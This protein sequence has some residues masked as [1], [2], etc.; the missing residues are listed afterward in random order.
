MKEFLHRDLKPDNVLL[1]E[2]GIPK[3]ADFGLAKRIFA[4]DIKEDEVLVGTPNFMAPELFQGTPAT[5]QS[6]VYSLGV[7]YFYLLTGTLPFASGS[8]SDLRNRAI[9]EP[10]PN[11]RETNPKIPL[12]DGRMFESADGEIAEEPPTRWN[13]SGSITARRRRTGSGYR[14]PAVGGF[15]KYR[16]DHLDSEKFAL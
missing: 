11:V 16:R 13:R 3:L 7:C 14:K 9:H 1:T 5:S 6:D 8:F 4:E 12:G 15:S 10:L 2:L